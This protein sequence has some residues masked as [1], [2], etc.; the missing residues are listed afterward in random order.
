M[1]CVWLLS[2]NRGKAEELR[3]IY[4]SKNIAMIYVEECSAYVFLWEFYGIQYY[5]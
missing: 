4:I 5:I 3:Q 2:C 1:C